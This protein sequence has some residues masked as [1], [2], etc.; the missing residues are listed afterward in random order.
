M[1]CAYLRATYSQPC[2]LAAAFGA[3]VA[4]EED[5]ARPL[6]TLELTGIHAPAI[7]SRL[8]RTEQE[9][10]L[11]NGL[12]PIE[13]D[14]AG[15]PAIVRAVTTYTVDASGVADTSLLDLTTIRTLDYVR[16]ACRTRIA[17]R[18]PRE[19]LNDATIKSVKSE[20][21][22]VLGR[23]EDLAIVEHVEANKDLLVV[24]R[25]AQDPNRID[26]AIPAD[27]V[28]GLHVFAG[29]IDLIL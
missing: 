28:N 21:L 11:Y 17:L 26:A 1:A 23:L 16:K 24:E 22:D 12:T 25:N 29:R 2:E 18:F 10:C 6:N 20:L 27:V 8:T 4:F 9:N 19:K 7:G 14:S 5:P 13:V 3:L 15:A